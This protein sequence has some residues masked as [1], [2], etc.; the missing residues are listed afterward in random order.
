MER[1]WCLPISLFALIVFVVKASSLSC[2]PDSQTTLSLVGFFPCLRDAPASQLS[3]CD[4]MILGSVELAIEDINASPAGEYNCFR[5]NLTHKITN[6][7]SEAVDAVKEYGFLNNR[8][9]AQPTHGIL[10]PYS[11]Q[12]A[13]DLSYIFGRLFNIIQVTYSV[14]DSR[15]KDKARYPLLYSITPTDAFLNRLRSEVLRHFGWRKVAV[16][17]SDSARDT[18]VAEELADV[19][20]NSTNKMSIMLGSFGSTAVSLLK[21]AKSNDVRVFLPI[22][23]EDKAR[24]IFCEAYQSG[25]TSPSHVWILPGMSRSNWWK[26]LDNQTSNCT[27]EVILEAIN[28]TL[29]VDTLPFDI[30]L[31]KDV[32]NLT[33]RVRERLN[34]PPF[35]FKNGYPPSLL[36]SK[37]FSAYD[38]VKLLAITW[39][40][41]IN[42]LHNA[43]TSKG[44]NATDIIRD[45]M[46]D[47]TLGHLLMEKLIDA[48]HRYT[49]FTLLG[50]PMLSMTS[51]GRG[52]VTQMFG[53]RESI[54]AVY[55]HTIHEGS[56]FEVCTNGTGCGLSWKGG[57]QP[58]DGTSNTEPDHVLFYVIFFVLYFF[59]FVGGISFSIITCICKT[60]K[61]L[62]ARTP[63][64]TAILN[65]CCTGLSVSG[66]FYLV[67]NYIGLVQLKHIEVVSPLCAIG[68]VVMQLSYVTILATVLVK[69]WRIYR[70]FYN[71]H[72]KNRKNLSTK[73]LS[74]GISAIVVP[75]MITITIIY[76]IY[77]PKE[78][79]NCLEMNDCMCLNR[80]GMWNIFPFL[81][82]TILCI[83]LVILGISNSQLQSF[84]RVEGQLANVVSIMFGLVGASIFIIQLREITSRSVVPSF[85]KI[86]MVHVSIFISGFVFLIFVNAPKIRIRQLNTTRHS[87]SSTSNLVSEDYLEKCKEIVKLKEQ[88]DLLDVP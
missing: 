38:A 4:L 16:F 23:S 28:S 6:N 14:T 1:W 8:F 61:Y 63:F 45:P 50:E 56:H 88:L 44:L 66:I 51:T 10:G 15:L 55:R 58:T 85:S 27:D 68:F 36:H 52:M 20:Y 71:P 25:L 59:I 12:V 31:T 41:T 34:L 74:L 73:D 80:L 82:F 30:S 19:L 75:F 17:S 86:L 49:G 78:V 47:P 21:I 33:L 3:H 67:S 37:M 2:N 53:N 42:H 46:K 60:N 18:K 62:K 32:Q 43:N 69:N 7:A 64:F 22:V 40:D 29:F 79:E 84:F 11:N 48:T 54:V 9:L 72:I 65:V 26:L 13:L 77:P 39:N 70:I 87:K 81:Y 57:Y 5:L 24:A 35:D 76:S 83:G